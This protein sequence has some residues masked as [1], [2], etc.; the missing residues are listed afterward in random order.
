[1]YVHSFHIILYGSL[2]LTPTDA[3]IGEIFSII[4]YNHSRFHETLGYKKPISIYYDSLKI[5]D[6]SYS[7]SSENS[8]VWQAKREL[9][10]K[11]SCLDILG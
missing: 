3:S 9:D 8:V 5:N 4:F 2:N 1:M 11:K 7:K 10:F 6:T